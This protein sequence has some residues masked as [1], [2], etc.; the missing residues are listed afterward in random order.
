LLGNIEAVEAHGQFGQCGRGTVPVIERS[1]QGR[2]NPAGGDAT[3]AVCRYDHELPVGAAIVQCRESH[4]GT[5]SGGVTAARYRAEGVQYNVA[6][7]TSDSLSR[8][9]ADWNRTIW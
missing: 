7:R 8:P 3:L 6:F 2:S 5:I 9:P 4:E 1:L